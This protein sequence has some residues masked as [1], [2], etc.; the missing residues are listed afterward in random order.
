MSDWA[1]ISAL[2]AA[3]LGNVA[4]TIVLVAAFFRL[5][6][7]HRGLRHA[8]CD[9]RHDVEQLEHKLAAMRTRALS[10]ERQLKRL[11]PTVDAE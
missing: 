9:A 7:R 6:R 5:R 8:Y 1:V 10:A 2:A 4:L 11:P 3:L